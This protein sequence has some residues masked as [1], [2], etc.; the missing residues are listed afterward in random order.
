VTFAPGQVAELALRLVHDAMTILRGSRAEAREQREHAPGRFADLWT[1]LGAAWS[2]RSGDLR[3]AGPAARGLVAAYPDLWGALLIDAT[4]TSRHGEPTRALAETRRLRALRDTRLVRERELDLEGRLRETDPAWLP[5]LSGEP[6]VL[7]PGD[8]RVVMHMLKASLPDRQSGYTIRSR[9]VLRA[10]AEAGLRP[11]V[12]TPYGY[13]PIA[14]RADVPK[15]EVVEGIRHHRLAPGADLDGLRGPDQLERTAALA[16]DVVRVERPAVIHVASGHRGYEYALVAAALKRSLGV[17]MV[18]EVRGFLE[19]SWTNDPEVSAIAADAELTR[20]RRA[21]EDRMMAAADGVTTLGSA[22]RAE[23]VARGVPEDKVVVVPNGIDPEAFQP[24]PSDDELRRRYG[25]EGRWVFGYISNMDHVRE[26]QG[27]LIETTARLV[28][29]GRRVACLLVGDGDLRAGLEADAARAG[30][31]DFVIFTGQVPHATV[32]AHYALLDAFV[33]P[34]MADRA[35]RFVTPLKPY[36]AMAMGVPLVVSDVPAL[37]EIAT[38][39]ERGLSFPVGDAEGLQAALE[40][41]MDHP[42]LA[43]ALRDSA[44]AWVLAE[45]TW[46]AN[47]PRYRDLYERVVDGSRATHEAV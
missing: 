34:R 45:R 28:A 19:E 46:A 6:E 32:A 10:Q 7:A 40:R 42:E 4:W 24:M 17:P 29:A 5:V 26:G 41:L 37:T 15:S 3:A 16:A 36:E 30:V 44:R 22:M 43:T 9:E 18:Y 31:R 1:Y 13:P 20:R 33:V 8:R 39:D 12:V 47:G 14:A 11:F 23:L 35:S 25:L 2:A 38:P 21:Q 27:L